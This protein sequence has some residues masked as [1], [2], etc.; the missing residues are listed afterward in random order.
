MCHCLFISKDMVYRSIANNSKFRWETH[1]IFIY[2]PNGKLDIFPSICQNMKEWH[3]IT[4]LKMRITYRIMLGQYMI[5]EHNIVTPIHWT[6]PHK[7][8]Y[9]HFSHL[10]MTVFDSTSRPPTWVSGWLAILSPTFL[11]Y[12]V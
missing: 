6:R 8:C 7:I 2:L 1:R 11:K 5:Y 10:I 12:G 4:F 3:F 9:W